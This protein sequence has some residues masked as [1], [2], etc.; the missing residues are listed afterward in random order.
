MRLCHACLE[1]KPEDAFYNRKYRKSINNRCIACERAKKKVDI[2]FDRSYQYKLQLMD[3]EE[4]RFFVCNVKH[5]SIHK[6]YHPLAFFETR[7]DRS[8]GYRSYCRE[9]R[10]ERKKAQRQNNKI[11]YTNIQQILC[12]RW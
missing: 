2:L 12:S 11:T 1:E 10:K 9:V 6:K 7:P 4:K 5:C 8:D 3:T